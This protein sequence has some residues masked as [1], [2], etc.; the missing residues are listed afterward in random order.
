[1]GTSA[2]NGGIVA[3]LSGGANLIANVFELQLRVVSYR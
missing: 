1:M 2:I 3:T